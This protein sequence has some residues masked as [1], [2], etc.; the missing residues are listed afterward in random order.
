MENEL[1]GQETHNTPEGDPKPQEGGE[2]T[3]TTTGD[4][5]TPEQIADLKK[6]ADVS[7]Q[8]FER[9]KKAEEELKKLKSK[10]IEKSSD[11][12]LPQRLSDEDLIYFAT[13]KLHPEDLTKVRTHMEKY[14]VGA[15]DAHDFL[16]PIL[17]KDSEIRKSAAA[18]N[19]DRSPRGDNRPKG[20][21][22]LAH[23]VRG[24]LPDEND[25][26]SIKAL[27]EAEAEAKKQVRK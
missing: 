6:R 27:V 13:E 19:T 12:S 2:E 4:E 26:A 18:S 15:K 5:L 3:P 11:S 16:K 21:D 25:E 7:S 20:A 10:K 22:L 24:Q 23:A 8:N 17:E 1:E 9:A 14:G